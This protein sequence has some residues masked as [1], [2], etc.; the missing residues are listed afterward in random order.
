[1]SIL[2]GSCNL[3]VICTADDGWA[4]V[5]GYRDIIQ[6]VAVIST[7][8]G[9]FCTGFLVNNVNNDC[10]PFFMTANHCGIG[11]NNA[12]SLVTYWNFEN[13]VCRQPNSPASGAAGDG[14]LNDFNTGAIFRCAYAPSDMTLVELDDPVSETANAFFAGW[15]AEYV[16]PQDTII[17]IHHPSTD[18]KRISFE[19]EPSQPGNGLNDIVVDISN[20]DHIIIPDWD[21]GTTEPGSSGSPLYNNQ[22]QV[23]GQLH[24]GGAACGNNLYDSYGWFNTSW[25]GAGTPETALK[26][27]LDPEDTGILNIPGKNCSFNVSTE[28]GSQEVCAPEDAV[29]LLT[30]SDNFSADVTLS[31]TNL[32]AGAMATF[33]PNPVVPGSASTLTI[34]TPGISEGQY[35]IQIN[36]TDGIETSNS[37][38]SLSVLSGVPVITSLQNPPDAAV[39]QSTAPQYTWTT[40]VGSSFE[41]EI[42]TDANFTNIVDMASGLSDP[43]YNGIF[44]EVLTTYYWRVRGQNEC[45]QGEWSTVWSFTTAEIAC[46]ALSSLDV[47]ISITGDGE[48]V[49]TSTLEIT[50]AGEIIDLNVEGLDISHTWVGDLSATLESPEGT[51]VQLFGEP[52]CQEDNMLVSFD[53][54]ATNT[55]D[56][57][58]VSCDNTGTAISGTYQPTQ[59][60]SA[61]NG[62]S[63][64]GTWTLTINDGA[65]QD[66]G[67]INAWSLGLCT[68]VLP[69][70]SIISNPA[71]INVCPI[72]DT[73]FD[74]T[75]GDGFEGPVTLS[76]SGNPSGSVVIFGTNPVAPGESTTVNMSGVGD[77]GTYTLTISG[78]DGTSTTNTTIEYTVEGAPDM[79]MLS[80]PSNGATDISINPILSWQSA[81]FTSS[82]TM[83]LATDIDFSNIVDMSSTGGTDINTT[84]LDYGTTYYW[85]V[86]ATGNCGTSMSEV[87]SFTTL[88]DLAV[89][90]NPGQ[91]VICNTMDQDFSIEVGSSFSA[92]SSISYSIS[93]NVAIDVNY[94]VDPDNVMPGS[95]VTA[96]LSNLSGIAA[97]V[98]TIE[99]IIEDDANQN[100][101]S[102][103]L[104][105]EAAPSATSL[106]APANGAVEIDLLTNLQ[107]TIADAADTYLL[108][109]A[110]DE[111]FTNIVASEMIITSGLTLTSPLE[112]STQYYW[113]VTST[114]DCGGTVS[115]VFSFTTIIIDAVFE[116]DGSHYEILPNPTKG[117][118][119]IRFST[120]LD[121]D[122]KI[123]VYAINGQLL[124]SHLMA[125]SSNSIQLDLSA[126]TSG[127]Y[128]FKLISNQYAITNRIILQK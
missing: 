32:P 84:G 76:I 38:I 12:P 106:S 93:P 70:V 56:D 39:D 96:T 7:G 92:P 30:V 42:A 91:V 82:Y 121:R 28:P 102:T 5:D 85:R 73:S 11:P 45:G 33:S 128:L 15:S 118:V 97:G 63:A 110:T 113:R 60:L 64:T 34:N 47:P 107:W 114:N 29:Y 116:L 25:E 10:T 9:T 51:I 78:D 88:L 59:P 72:Q 31:A 123:E 23:V 57:F 27:W 108:E 104:T 48:P 100:M 126:Y 90:V 21:I 109:I 99:F 35:S 61:F 20:A 43:N 117:N 46:G 127:V 55:A 89:N 54:S 44:L 125:Q 22:K 119:D 79:T 49:V 26:F 101:A 105:V 122:L 67:T 3:D 36:G 40:A 65:D 66:G 115:E 13:S 69:D 1:M 37:Q 6:S 16:M 81:M 94:D 103:N 8:G 41:I 74:L 71:Q 24:G 17:A 77:L 52:D 98:Y 124:Q 80:L 68:V 4:I 95:T 2:S 120:A 19:F 86:T 87:F 112:A 50:A 18:E 75:V 111:L 62:E 53:D 58:L 83:E 14:Q